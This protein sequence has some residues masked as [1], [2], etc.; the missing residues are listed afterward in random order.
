M[1][2]RSF[3]AGVGISPDLVDFG[4][5]I[6]LV[7]APPRLDLDRFH[8]AV[9][10]EGHP[11]TRREERLVARRVDLVERL[12]FRIHTAGRA[13]ELRARLV[14]TLVHVEVARIGI[15]GFGGQRTFQ[16]LDA[17]A[18]RI[19]GRELADEI[20][21][22]HAHV[23]DLLV[24]SVGWSEQVVH[25]GQLQQLPDIGLVVDRRDVV[26]CLRREFR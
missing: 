2:P 24:R 16:P 26:D 14:P 23:D 11:E 10:A 5:V 4:I 15:L 9:D 13:V 7:A 17:A 8:V 6:A 3:L 20:T 1:G 12:G 25:D 21:I 18:V 22:A 19:H